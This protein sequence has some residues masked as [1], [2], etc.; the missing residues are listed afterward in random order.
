MGSC[1]SKKSSKGDTEKAIDRNWVKTSGCIDKFVFE[2]TAKS[3]RYIKIQLLLL[4]NCYRLD[5]SLDPLLEESCSIN[6]SYLENNKEIIIKGIPNYHFHQFLFCMF[7]MKI[8][9][10]STNQDNFFSD[11]ENE[12]LK[13]IDKSLFGRNKITSNFLNTKGMLSLDKILHCLREEFPLLQYCPILPR[14]VQMLLW[15]VPEKVALKMASAMLDENNKSD[16]VNDMIRTSKAANIKY[17]STNIKFTKGLKSF[18][19]KK[20]RIVADKKIANKILEDLIDNMCLQIIPVEV[21]GI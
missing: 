11:E 9:E 18:A 3:N 19:R 15:Y 2:T 5:Y 6:A 16:T 12:K 21:I 20:C 4:R 1:T 14:V 7:N 17:F 10:Y 13:G 8:A